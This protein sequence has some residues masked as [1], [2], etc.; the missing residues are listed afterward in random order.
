MTPFAALLAG[1]L[2]AAPT[3]VAVM[4]LTAGE[5]V[6]ASVAASLGAAVVG[7]LRKKPNIR[8]VTP[9]DVKTALS[10]EQQKLATS[11][12][13][14]DRCVIDLGSAM[15]ADR[16]VTGS[17]SRLGQSWLIHLQLI[18]TRKTQT[19][20]QSDRR[21]KG[22]SVDDVLDELP[23]M[24]SELFGTGT[25]PLVAQG[26]A[27]AA[28]GTSGTNAV[29]AANPLPPV[30]M[31]TN[32]LPWA[33]EPY[34][35]A[36]ALGGKLQ[37][38]TDGKGGYVAA[39]KTDALHG[40]V[41]WGDATRLYALSRLGGGSSGGE[42]WSFNFWD[43][44][45]NGG[46]AGSVE[47]G[48][49]KTSYWCKDK[50]FVLTPVPEGQAKVFFSKAKLL[51]GRW[52]RSIVALARDDEGSYFLV[53]RPGEQRDSTDLRLYVGPKGKL[54]AVAVTGVDRDGDADFLQTAQGR[55]KLPHASEEDKDKPK[56]EWIVSGNKRQLTLLNTWTSAPLIYGALGAYDRPVELGT[57]C[58][59]KL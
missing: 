1:L 17:V 42:T 38:F 26:P 27:Q 47:H 3:P 48:E 44:R 58:D 49:A 32:P 23:A 24:A 25:A 12:C 21:K 53:D 59:G 40:P 19:L 54:G 11:G 13:S 35:N 10:I 29:A 43:P 46:Q 20:A 37:L 15:G 55:L 30:A 4:P 5:G 2:Q 56:A 41:F 45:T 28:A 51:A 16:V 8:V 31:A 52:R 36:G 34:P 7:E 57:P 6:T 9:E 22:G 18:D 39:Q 14:D 50:E 33:D